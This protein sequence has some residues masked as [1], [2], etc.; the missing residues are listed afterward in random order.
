MPPV[1]A[2]GTAIYGAVSAFAVAS[3][4][5]FNAVVAVGLSAASALLQRA[6]KRATPDTTTAS[7]REVN[8]PQTRV[9]V[10]DSTPVH[11]VVLGRTRFAGALAF[12]PINKPP[13][14]IVQW[15]HS[16]LPIT[17]FDR[18]YLGEQIVPI[19]PTGL[20]LAEPFLRA[21]VP[22]LRVVTQRGDLDQ[23]VNPLLAEELGWSDD[24]RLPGIANTA[25]WFDFGADQDV[26]RELWE[27]GLPSLTWV[28]RGCP[29]PD[30]RNPTHRLDFDPHDLHDLH[31]AMATWEWSNNAALIGLFAALMP[32]GLNIGPASTDWHASIPQIDFDDETIGLHHR[33]G[34][35]RRHTADVFALL[36]TP[37]MTLMESLQSAN[38]GHLVDRQ[39][40]ISIAGSAPRKPLLTITDDMLAGP[41]SFRNALPTDRRVDRLRAAFVSNERGYSD[42]E[43]T[44]PPADLVAPRPREQTPRLSA[45]N[46]APRAARLLKMAFDEA[47]FPKFLNIVCD[48]RALG[49][50]E[51][52]VF[53]FDC[54][55][56][57]RRNGLYQV[58]TWERSEDGTMVCYAASQY[59]PDIA[60]SWVPA[61]DEPY[62][63][64]AAELA[65]GLPT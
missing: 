13:R 42:G 61:R 25:A 22:M 34:F 9:T 59:E 5:I 14:L 46:G 7:P 58:E 26:H 39:G 28:G 62:Y 60:R 8:S 16:T 3:P 53:R 36:D 6:Q 17:S 30:P 45:T 19:G 52:D 38:R 41:V 35:E 32:F 54:T 29:I 44:W 10:R 20:P 31:A 48:L 18:L 4:F 65:E 43:M 15:L 33:G 2:L 23:G 1:V 63:E 12:P 49:L 11:Q 51:G 50:V 40:R 56:W 27:G 21:S 64:T 47:Q 24:M 57:P 55:R 37:P